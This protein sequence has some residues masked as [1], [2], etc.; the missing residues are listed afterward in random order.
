MKLKF[1][2][3]RNKGRSNFRKHN[4]TFDEART[5]FSDEFVITFPDDF[6]S[7]IEDRFISIGVSKK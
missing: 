2:W 7:Q 1:E 5:I 3:D 4:V 6:H